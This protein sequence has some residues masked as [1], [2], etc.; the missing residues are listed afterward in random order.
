MRTCSAPVWLFVQKENECKV[1]K[2]Y[3]AEW[4]TANGSLNQC[5]ITEICD[6]RENENEKEMKTKHGHMQNATSTGQVLNS[7][8]NIYNNHLRGIVAYIY[9]WMWMEIIWFNQPF[10]P[11]ARKFFFF[12]IFIFCWKIVTVAVV[13]LVHFVPFQ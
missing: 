6:G 9:M 7:V 8:L 1:R 5:Y 4:L 2:V 10:D 3:F 11:V 12:F 13:L